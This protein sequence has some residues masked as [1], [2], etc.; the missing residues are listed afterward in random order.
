MLKGELLARPTYRFLHT[1]DEGNTSV[2]VVAE[3]DIFA[4]KVV[5]KTV[6]MLGMNDT[7]AA[8]EPELLKRIEHDCIVRVWEAQ[9]EPEPRWAGLEAITFVTEYYEGESIY[10]AMSDGH[11]FGVGDVIRVAERVLQAL[12]HMHVAHGLL[13]RDVKPGN[14]MLDTKRKTA[15]LGDLGSAAYI[16]TA[17]GGARGH[18]GSPLYLAPEARKLGLV[19]PRS[20]LY[21]LGVTLIEMLHGGFPYEELV[22]TTIDQRLDEGR[23]ALTDRYLR[24]AP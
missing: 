12:D 1:I 3:H 9:W 7:V 18:L 4:C 24:P 14:V 21:S 15:Y 13:H 8:S 5:Q 20:D 2:C 19:T 11:R 10:K 22:D 17:T 23:R 6:S 16:E